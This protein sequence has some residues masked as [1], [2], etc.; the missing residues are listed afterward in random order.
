VKKLKTK[1][2]EIFP[3]DKTREGVIETLAGCFYILSDE[4][5]KHVNVKDLPEVVGYHIGLGMNIVGA[6]LGRFSI[7]DPTTYDVT[8]SDADYDQK[9]EYVVDQLIY[10]REACRERR[11]NEPSYED[12]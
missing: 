12:K 10:L 4:L 8:Y 7:P 11:K 2:L 1:T 9:L 6:I 5:R 3:D